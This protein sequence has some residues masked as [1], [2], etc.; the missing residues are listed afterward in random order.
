MSHIFHKSQMNEDY[1][2]GRAIIV[3]R[4]LLLQTD[5]P[6]SPEK[7]PI[8]ADLPTSFVQRKQ[9][10]RM[11]HDWNQQETGW[12]EQSISD[13]LIRP[14]KW[15]RLKVYHSLKIEFGHTFTH[16][17][18]GFSAFPVANVTHY[19]LR[20]AFLQSVNL[21]CR[22]NKNQ[23]HCPLVVIGI[24]HITE[25]GRSRFYQCF[26]LHLVFYTHLNI[27]KYQDIIHCCINI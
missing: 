19:A 18:I 27:N 16:I 7:S 15:I 10:D 3:L 13:L 11:F 9:S 26:F 2:N 21:K 24:H 6:W 20:S 17:F 12:G 4:I 5:H 8:T 22:Y 14:E 1:M 25:I 23:Q